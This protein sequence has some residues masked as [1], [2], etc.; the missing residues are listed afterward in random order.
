MPTSDD[1][2]YGDQEGMGYEDRGVSV[3]DDHDT[4]YPDP[5]DEKELMREPLD[6]EMIK[7]TIR[8]VVQQAKMEA[9]QPPDEF[10]E[11][12]DPEDGTYPEPDD[13]L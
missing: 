5:D 13:F 11:A 6:G 8:S 12:T 3:A 7:G 9:K 4:G 1:M 10:G 2:E